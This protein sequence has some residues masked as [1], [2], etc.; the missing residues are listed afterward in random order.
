[1]LNKRGMDCQNKV[2]D[3]GWCNAPECTVAPAVYGWGYMR[4]YLH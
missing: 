2:V 3:V 4:E 1:M